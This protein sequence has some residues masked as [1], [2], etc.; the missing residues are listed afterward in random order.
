[1]ELSPGLTIGSYRLVAPAGAGGMAED[2]RAYHPRLDSYVAI[3]FLSPR[4]GMDP[5][6]LDRF[7]REARA[8][9]RLEHPNILTVHDFGEQDAWTYMVSPFVGGGTLEARLR[10]GAWTVEE[11]A[12]V[13]APL[14]DAL[15]YAH[16]EGL[17]HRDVKPSNVLFTERG[18]LVL[19][20]FGIARMVEGTTLLSHTGMIIGTPLYMSPEQAD[21]QRVGPLSDQY[22]LGVVAY[23]M[24]TGRPP[25]IAETPVALLVAHMHKPLPPPRRLNPALPE[26]AEAALFKVLAKDPAD[27]FA[28]GV[29]FVTA[30]QARE[31]P[32]DAE[33]WASGR[34]SFT[35][36]ATVVPSAIIPPAT[37]RADTPPPSVS[38][39]PT[40]V[41][42]PTPAHGAPTDVSPSTVLPTAGARPSEAPTPRG[43]IPLPPQQDAVRA[44]PRRMTIPT[45]AERAEQEQL[46]RSGGLFGRWLRILFGVLLAIGV[47]MAAMNWPAL[48]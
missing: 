18:R 31:R 8:V 32:D 7:L 6:Y 48:R 20:D 46:E 40:D 22:S 47:V 25:F 1:M 41:K 12:A 10:R 30:L 28:S 16:G 4:Y 21:G 45:L 11:A 38:L 29:D 43:A 37:S 13:L 36:E 44:T 42:P 34:P 3:K 19:S 17:V 24:L 39:S 26:R 9:S 27:R 15:D 23:Q 14:A 35:P 5:A 2:W 33:Q